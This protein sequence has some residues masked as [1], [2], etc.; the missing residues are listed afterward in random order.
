MYFT[1]GLLPTAAVL[2][3]QLRVPTEAH[4]A[5][6]EATKLDAVGRRTGLGRG[7]RPHSHISSQEIVLT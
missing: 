3:K 5:N 1:R 4:G 6:H 7:M 2:S